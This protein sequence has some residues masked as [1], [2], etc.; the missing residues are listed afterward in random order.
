MEL[1]TLSALVELFPSCARSSSSVNRCIPQS[2]WWTIAT[3]SVPIICWLTIRLRVASISRP[4]AFRM[5]CA[6]P[7]GMPS[8]RIGSIRASMQNKCDPGCTRGLG[9]ELRGECTVGVEKGINSCH[10]TSLPSRGLRSLAPIVRIPIPAR[11]ASERSPRVPVR[12]RHIV[13]A[14]STSASAVGASTTDRRS[15]PGPHG[16][17][18][19]ALAVGSRGPA[20]RPWQRPGPAAPE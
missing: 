15:P 1:D 9:S 14:F 12:H 20:P 5:M 19:A 11:L 3:S 4:P 18:L 10:V 8:A 13:C 6:C 2:V 17:A 16:G 7:G